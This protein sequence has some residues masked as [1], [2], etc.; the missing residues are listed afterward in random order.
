MKE[1][2]RGTVFGNVTA[3]FTR[4]SSFTCVKPADLFL[5]GPYRGAVVNHSR[6]S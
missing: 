4:I 3:R 1:E 2:I 6:L 5:D